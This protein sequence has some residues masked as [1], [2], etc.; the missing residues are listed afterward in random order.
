AVPDTK[1]ALIYLI[2]TFLTL[3]MYKEL[4]KNYME[5]RREKLLRF[6]KA[7]ECFSDVELEIY[8]FISEKSDFYAIAEKVSRASSLMPYNLIMK[9]NRCKEEKDTNRRNHL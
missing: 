1:S 6:E 8:K 3:W 4:R 9:Y 2:L 5:S 7:I